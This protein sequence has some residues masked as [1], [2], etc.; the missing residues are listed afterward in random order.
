MPSSNQTGAEL[1]AELVERYGFERR[2]AEVFG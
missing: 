1:S 2:R